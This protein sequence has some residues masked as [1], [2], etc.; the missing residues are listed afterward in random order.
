MAYLGGWRNA[1][2]LLRPPDVTTF[3]QDLLDPDDEARG[4]GYESFE[5]GSASLYVYRCRACGRC[6][7]TWDCD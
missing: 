7:S 1:V 5:S 2:E 3:F 4:R 6:R